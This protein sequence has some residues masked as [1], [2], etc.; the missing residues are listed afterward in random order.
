MKKI[1]AGIISF[2]MVLSFV[3][4][5]PIPAK[6]AI[7]SSGSCGE[8]ITWELDDSGTLTIKGTG[9]MTDYD[10]EYIYNYLDKHRQKVFS[11]WL[12]SEEVKEVIIE[13]GVTSIGNYSF[14]GCKN[15]KRVTI[16]NGVTNF[17]E[18][19]FNSCT[20]LEKINI[21]NSVTT[22]EHYVFEK[23]SSLKSL[24]IPESVTYIGN[25]AFFECKGLK[26]LNIPD[27]VT[28]LGGDAFNSCSNLESV[29]LSKSL[30]SIGFS[31]FEK[32]TSIK[33]V[34][35]PYGV[36]IIETSAFYGCTSLESVIIPNS[37]TTLQE[38]LFQHCTS[39]KSITIPGSVTNATYHA[40]AGST[41]FESITF[42]SGIT[43]LSYPAGNANLKTLNIPNTISEFDGEFDEVS[44]L[45][46]NFNGTRE[47]WNA[48][49]QDVS[50]KRAIIDKRV[51][52]V[53]VDDKT[54]QRSAATQTDTKPTTS[55]KPTDSSN[56][57]SN[58]PTTSSKPA[59][60]NTSSKASEQVVESGVESNIL[61]ENETEQDIDVVSSEISSQIEKNNKEASPI[62]PIAVGAGVFVLGAGAAVGIM[63]ILKKKNIF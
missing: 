45:T 29:T 30:T 31:L 55:S 46:V 48:V 13:A 3:C 1:L 36:T 49:E 4:V 44:G 62:I 52:I 41:S 53:C 61:I 56:T 59:V 34:D 25:S 10:H 20:S 8:N 40:F 21:P 11:P 35:I 26:N 12:N 54:A 63:L 38:F 15:L 32:C 43:S 18:G 6:A 39:L 14:K 19:S 47:E 17:G 24:D 57:T 5:L 42:L 37:V 22:I 28:S 51:T 2:I 60:N 7:V 33:R 27:S 9:E 58:N 50:L 23:C 16:P